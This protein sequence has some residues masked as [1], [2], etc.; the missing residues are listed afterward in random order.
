MLYFILILW[1]V[2]YPLWKGPMSFLFY[3]WKY[4]EEYRGTP[5]LSNQ[6]Q[7]MNLYNTCPWHTGAALNLSRARLFVTPWTAACQAALSMGILQARI[8]E[9]VAMPSSMGSFQPRDQTQVSH[10]AREF[11]TIWWITSNYFRQLS[12]TFWWKVEVRVGT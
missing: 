1:E 12:R 10:I 11:F 9:W 2:I 7:V 3:L 4:L 8:L 6:Y 5:H